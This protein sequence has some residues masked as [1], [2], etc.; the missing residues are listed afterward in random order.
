MAY[1]SLIRS[2]VGCRGARKGTLL[3]GENPDSVGWFTKEKTITND[4]NYL[5][6]LMRV[7][8]TYKNNMVLKCR[9]HMNLIY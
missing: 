7:C 6:V 9:I 5:I 8:H 1:F 2:Q 3:L 4:D